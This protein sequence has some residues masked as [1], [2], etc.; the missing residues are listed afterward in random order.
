MRF[1]STISCEVSIPYFLWG[2]SSLY[3]LR[4]L[5]S[6]SFEVFI[7]YFLTKRQRH[8][9][10]MGSF[11]KAIGC[12]LQL[13]CFKLSNP[14]AAAALTAIIKYCFLSWAIFPSIGQFCWAI[15]P[16]IVQ[17]YWAILD[18]IDPADRGAD[19]S[20]EDPSSCLENPMEMLSEK[21][22]KVS[23]LFFRFEVKTMQI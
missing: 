11:P 23:P 17:L 14:T 20:P 19:I 5:F 7:F 2:F 4:F 13:Y 3:L 15:F 12:K 9:A 8:L 22:V 18:N 1:I 21:I 10:F 6:I 16:S